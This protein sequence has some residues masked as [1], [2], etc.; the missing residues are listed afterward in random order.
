MMKESTHRICSTTIPTTSLGLARPE[1]CVD[2][3][4]PSRPWAKA[5]EKEKRAADNNNFRGCMQ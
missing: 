3:L 1:F 4:A 2:I 5:K